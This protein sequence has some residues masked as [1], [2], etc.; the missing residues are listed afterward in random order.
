M[1]RHTGSIADE[2]P[3]CSG[4]EKAPK[5]WGQVNCVTTDR[6]REWK[7]M[8]SEFTQHSCG[9]IVNGS[10]PYDTSDDAEPRAVKEGD[11]E[12]SPG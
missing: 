7:Q 9:T 2:R 1:G 3:S 6:S 12:A 10:D 4:K 5:L 11:R 8:Y